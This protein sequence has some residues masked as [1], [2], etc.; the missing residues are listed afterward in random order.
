[1]LDQRNDV[2]HAENTLSHTLGVKGLQSVELLGHPNELEWLAGH[3]PDRKRCTPARVTVQLGQDDTREGQSVVKRLSDVDCVLTLHRVDD[4]QGLDGP[5]NVVELT[6]LLHHG[7]V[8]AQTPGRVDDKYVVV[9]SPRVIKRIA[10]NF[11]RRLV[12][13]RWHEVDAGLGRYG[14][15]LLDSSRTV[16]VGADYQD[17]LPARFAAL[18]RM[19]A[20][21]QPACQLTRRG[22]FTRTLQPGHKNDRWWLLGQR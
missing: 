2:A 10:C 1:L 13:V 17:F 7:F 22:G 5:Q 14:L 18:M 12:G 21:R 15:Q 16:D 9:M 8:D 20:F 19:V 6:D 11:F 4:K 3:L